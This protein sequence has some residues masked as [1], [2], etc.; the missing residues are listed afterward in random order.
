[1][2]NLL[3]MLTGGGGGRSDAAAQQEYETQSEPAQEQG[4]GGMGGMLNGLLSNIRPIITTVTVVVG[5]LT[6]I[7]GKNPMELIGGLMEKFGMS[8]PFGGN[9]EERVVEDA[10][11]GGGDPL[12][13]SSSQT[14][15]SVSSG[16]PATVEITSNDNEPN[17][18]ILNEH[19]EL[20]GGNNPGDQVTPASTVKSMTLL[21]VRKMIDEGTLP[22]N[23]IEE[24][25]ANITAMMSN[26]SNDAAIK[27]AVA[28]SGSEEAF[29]AEMNRVGQEIGL[30]N[31]EFTNASGHPNPEYNATGGEMYSTA[32]DMARWQWALDTH[33]AGTAQEFS[34]VEHVATLGNHI[35]NL[36]SASAQLDTGKTGTGNGP[37]GRINWE[38]AEA[39]NSARSFVG[40]TEG[41]R[42]EEQGHTIAVAE[43]P[44]DKWPEEI[45]EL[46]DVVG[47]LQS[48]EADAGRFVIATDVPDAREA[49]IGREVQVL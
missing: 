47:G 6:M 13:Q 28:A 25:R 18:A 46:L 22:E 16:R 49:Q 34:S 19:G 40:T 14:R 44:A 3:A 30:K 45:K 12:G 1:M 31:T 7:T 35:D 39:G 10:N 27:V 42:P 21:T 2:V 8:N 24:N 38:N 43:V 17:T 20:V 37:D 9:D 48:T 36:Q 33:Y 23:F 15:S 4:G 32:E 26:S 29:V 5:A 41:E 11:A